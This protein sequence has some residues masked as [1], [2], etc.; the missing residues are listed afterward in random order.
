[1]AALESL[2]EQQRRYHEERERIM[3]TMTRE[4]LR[5]KATHREQINSEHVV[6]LLLDRYTDCTSH[7]RDVY[8]DKD[9]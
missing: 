6:K 4:I 8:E 5:K 9:G 3:D 2:L 7:V 1:M